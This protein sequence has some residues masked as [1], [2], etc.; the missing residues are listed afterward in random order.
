MAYQ[1]IE[2]VTL[3]S[4]ASSIEF[5]AIPQDGVDLLVVYSLRQDTISNS[6]A[7]RFNNDSGS[8]YSS[9]RLI[10][11]GSGVSSTTV[12]LTQINTLSTSSDQTA[13]T[14]SNASLYISNYTSSS[15]KST[16]HDEVQ[17][18]N[19]T[20]SIQRL[21]A[22]RYNDSA[23]ITSIVAS[24]SSGSLIAGSTASLYKIS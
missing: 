10:G 19:A 17:E 3:T 15:A 11:N 16:S 14:F 7:V 21:V 23:A 22:G 5:T 9:I 13:S 1:L 24:L 20:D 6:P 2:T 8:N 12:T 4:A 18:N